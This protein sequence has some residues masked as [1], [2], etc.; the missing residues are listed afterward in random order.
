MCGDRETV[1]VS[2]VIRKRKSLSSNSTTTQS[3]LV[4]T[5]LPLL[6]NCLEI[7]DDISHRALLH[8]DGDDVLS[9][10]ATPDANE[11]VI[12]KLPDVGLER[13]FAAAQE[14]LPADAV[15]VLKLDG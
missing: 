14:L 10:R 6:F 8:G 1:V 4:L 12:P 15:E 3:L 5:L 9:L 2:C 13:V 7:T 11:F